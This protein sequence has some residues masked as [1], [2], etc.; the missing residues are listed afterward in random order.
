MAIAHQDLSKGAPIAQIP[1]SAPHRRAV[2]SVGMWESLATTRRQDRVLHGAAKAA[3]VVV[4]V[5]MLPFWLA[6]QHLAGRIAKRLGRASRDLGELPRPAPGERS[7]DVVVAELQAIPHRLRPTAWATL[8]KGLVDLSL[9]MLTQKR[10]TANFGYAYPRQFEHRVFNGGDGEPLAAVVGVH[11]E[12]RPGV[13]VVHGLLSSRLFDYVREIAVC[14]YYDWGFN[15]AVIDLRSFGLSE[16]L[17]PAPNT[18]GWK[19]G[20]D[21]IGAAR[22]LKGLGST[23]VGVLGISLG[24]SAGM[25]AAHNDGVDEAVDGGILAISG[26]GD[27]RMAAA[28]L[29]SKLSVRDPFYPFSRGFDVM[30]VSRVRNLGW[31]SNVADFHALMDAVV[32]PHYGLSTDEI[33]ERSSAVNHIADARVP[34]LILHAEDDPIVPVEHARMLEEAAAGNDRVRVWIL[35]GG[36]HAA[37]D[38]LDRRWTYAVY[39]GFFEALARYEPAVAAPVAA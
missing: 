24:A 21:V 25:N 19:E 29:D 32:S 1:P 33:Y 10:Q 31:P 39:R 17:T 20:E 18:G 22:F 14:A 36:G 28:Y 37:F 3:N 15:V 16:L 5:V 9:F 13:V 27:T 30:L 26:P 34:V 8:R 11:Q 23:S 6:G 7:L 35:P 12:P 38:A 4:G 2:G